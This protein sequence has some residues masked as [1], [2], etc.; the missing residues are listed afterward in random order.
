[1][2]TPVFASWTNRL[3]ELNELPLTA[4]RPH[5][6]DE[7]VSAKTREAM[8]RLVID[9]AQKEIAP[10][11]GVDRATALQ[12]SLAGSRLMPNTLPVAPVQRFVRHRRTFN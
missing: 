4:P 2:Y 8:D 11:G 3:V 5:P 6:N 7:R 9:V 1:M 10:N 12:S